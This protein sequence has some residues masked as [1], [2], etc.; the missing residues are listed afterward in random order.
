MIIRRVYVMECKSCHNR[1]TAVSGR[2][3]R[4]AKKRA[5]R[6]GWEIHPKGMLCPKHTL[7]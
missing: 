7:G 2:W 6:L 3:R 5:R 1:Q 4:G